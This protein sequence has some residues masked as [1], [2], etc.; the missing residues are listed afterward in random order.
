[1]GWLCIHVDGT[2]LLEILLRGMERQ[3]PLEDIFWWVLSP[4]RSRKC[5]PMQ[6]LLVITDFY[7]S[8]D[9]N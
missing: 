2:K 4:R 1:M 3:E 9:N 8:M 7:L 5:I 6:L